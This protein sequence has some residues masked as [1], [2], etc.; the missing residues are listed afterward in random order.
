MYAWTYEK[1]QNCVS[2]MRVVEDISPHS[3]PL[4]VIYVINILLGDGQENERVCRIV[5]SLSS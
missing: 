3:T 2:N 1:N 4:L 5:L